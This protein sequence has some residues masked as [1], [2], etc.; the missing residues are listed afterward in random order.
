MVIWRF[1][2]D[3]TGPAKLPSETVKV[4]LDVCGGPAGWPEILAVE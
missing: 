1:D 4:K 2:E 3:E